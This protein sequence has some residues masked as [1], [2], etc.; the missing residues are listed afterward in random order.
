MVQSQQNTVIKASC[1]IVKL[2]DKLET[3]KKT[4]EIGEIPSCIDLGTAA[5]G[6]LGH[7]NRQTNVKRREN[8]KP[9]LDFQYYHLCTPSQPYSE[10]L[11]GD[12]VTKNVQEIQN[13]NKFGR[14]ISSDDQYGR[15]S[16][17]GM[18]GRG[19]GRGR[20]GNRGH[21]GRC[22]FGRGNGHGRGRGYDRD[23]GDSHNA[24]TKNFRSIQR[25]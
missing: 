22:G 15:G 4:V 23:G 9:D 14:K 25:N 24:P 2:L 11:Y 12:D 16:D 17:F 7:Y 20:G 18:R 5:L 10:F 1:N 6:L 19:V 21:G 8:H 3:M 13:V